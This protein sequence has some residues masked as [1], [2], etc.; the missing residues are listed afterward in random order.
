MTQTLDSPSLRRDSG[1]V[2]RSLGLR[3]STATTTE[4]VRSLESQQGLEEQ[5]HQVLF[6]QESSSLEQRH[7]G[8]SHSEALM[9]ARSP[10]TST[11]SSLSMEFLR[12]AALD[13]ILSTFT[14]RLVELHRMR[15]TEGD[16]ERL[17]LDAV[18]SAVR[19]LVLADVHQ[20][21][22]VFALADG[23]LSMCWNLPSSCITIEFD[24]DGDQIALTRDTTG[25]RAGTLEQEFHH[26]V[27]ALRA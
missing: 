19:F 2:S 1:T 15:M 13:D 20:Q 21:P 22:Q 23:G 5:F 9:A 12:R 26:I 17:D 27:A 18:R 8:G 25:R 4:S 10:L 24:S 7:L 16:M 14:V 6:G 11:I 3:Q